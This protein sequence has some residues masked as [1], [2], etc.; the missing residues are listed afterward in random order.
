[1]LSR[2]FSIFL[3]CYFSMFVKSSIISSFVIAFSS[4]I[5][6]F[7][8]IFF[9]LGYFSQFVKLSIISCFVFPFS[10]FIN[11]FLAIFFFGYFSSIVSRF[12]FPLF[13]IFFL[14][15]CLPFTNSALS[16]FIS[17]IQ[18]LFILFYFINN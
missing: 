5:N 3:Y 2:L 11:I 17:V 12:V 8:A 16:L 14:R 1:M 18:L 7:L 10:S 6:I 9:F 15:Y 13:P 4:F